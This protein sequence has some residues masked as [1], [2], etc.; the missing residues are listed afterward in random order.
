MLKYVESPGIITSSVGTRF[1]FWQIDNWRYMM[2]LLLLPLDTMRFKREK[3]EDIRTF[4]PYHT[5]R[6]PPKN[7]SNLFSS[8]PIPS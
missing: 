1:F 5:P 4:V 7:L 3:I 2:L 8:N 6:P